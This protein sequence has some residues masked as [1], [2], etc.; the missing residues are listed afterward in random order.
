[1]STTPHARIEDQRGALSR[2]PQRSDPRPASGPVPSASN[3]RSS[4][5]G[6]EAHDVVKQTTNRKLLTYQLA[7]V[8]VCMRC[9]SR[10]GTLKPLLQSAVLAGTES[11]L[12]LFFKTSSNFIH[13]P[14]PSTLRCLLILTYTALLF[15]ISSTISALVLTENFGDSLGIAR[16]LRKKIKKSRVGKKLI[17]RRPTHLAELAHTSTPRRWRLMEYHCEL[18]APR[19]VPR[20]DRYPGL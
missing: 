5:G 4:T 10:D 6:P 15:S 16:R 19:C 12:L 1:M 13:A 7:A 20:L 14:A 17:S 11:Q 18:L 8:V 2:V 9:T 3:P